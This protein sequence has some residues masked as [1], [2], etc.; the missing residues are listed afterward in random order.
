VK[1]LIAILAL[2]AAIAMAPGAPDRATSII[3]TE[4]AG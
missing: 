3:G 2:I 1:H 4:S